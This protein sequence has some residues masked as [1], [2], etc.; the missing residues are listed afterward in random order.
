MAD[1]AS[2]GGVE[3]LGERYGQRP[4]ARDA[5]SQAGRSPAGEPSPHDSCEVARGSEVAYGVLRERVLH[6]TSE[7]LGLTA[8]RPGGAFA[9]AAPTTPQQAVLWVHADQHALLHG[10]PTDERA[11]HADFARGIEDAAELLREVGQCDPATAAWFEAVREAL[12]PFA[13]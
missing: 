11:L 3:P 10:V 12:G 13:D 9:T 2:V 8:V 5:R 6:A 7:R 4:P 1:L